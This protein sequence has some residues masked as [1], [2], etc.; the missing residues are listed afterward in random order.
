MS[1]SRF[2]WG[3]KVFAIGI[4]CSMLLGGC[5][6]KGDV[7]TGTDRI[8]KEGQVQDGDIFYTCKEI[9][10]PEP[11][12]AF[13]DVDENLI[14][15][16][17]G[18]V[19]DGNLYRDVTITDDVKQEFTYYRQ[20]LNLSEKEKADWELEELYSKKIDV[21]EEGA[22]VAPTSPTKNAGKNMVD[23]DENILKKVEGFSTVLLTGARTEQGKLYIANNQGIYEVVEDTPKLIFP[24]SPDY[25][26]DVI[27]G[28]EAKENGDI[29]LVCE[30]DYHVTLL[31]LRK[32]EEPV[33]RDREEI[34]L[35]L[36]TESQALNKSIARFNRQSEKYHIT[37]IFAAPNEDVRS[38]REKIIR[39]MTNGGGPDILN[40]D[41]FYEVDVAD[42]AENGYL[43][44]LDDLRPDSED[45]F[46]AAFDSLLINGK[47]YSIPFDFTIR[48][49]AY[50]PEVFTDNLETFSLQDMMEKVKTGNTEIL[51]YDRFGQGTSPYW[52]VM[53]YGLYDESNKAFIDW[54][55][56]LSHL[57]E[58]PFL[59]F[60][61]FAK[62]YGR[63]EKVSS[64]PTKRL[65]DGTVFSETITVDDLETWCELYYNFGGNPVLLGYPREDGNG[66]YLYGRE[67]Y[68][69]AN[70][71]CK[72]GA[73]EFLRFL[74]SREEQMRY[75][76]Y[77]TYEEMEYLGEGMSLYGYRADFPVYKDAMEVVFQRR[78]RQD[79][80]NYLVYLDGPVS[81]KMDER[82]EA[83]FYNIV[84]NAKPGRFR[85][86]DIADVV[87]EELQ[88][89]FEG[90][91]SAK[92]AA[93][94]LHERV[95][96]YL[97][98]QK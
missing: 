2:K 36:G 85:A 15:R 20:T 33:N 18:F 72:E 97:N 21:L 52:I 90:S 48:L 38:F 47:M 14:V 50:S 63:Q 37:T 80:K 86:D 30:M 57:N 44:C 3:R 43:E 4:V 62:E 98:E 92:E 95:Q 67:L 42:L 12:D 11:D 77:D 56:K 87:Y 23:V 51:S 76:R 10:F 60:L 58:E 9:A 46:Q 74:I 83:D 81:L 8:E 69:N 65:K 53:N 54:E 59:E 19:Y 16:K 17:G 75:V 78:R 70:S 82:M 29:D 28:M 45:Y 91:V 34:I 25:K 7:I 79:K 24:L 5:G 84:N 32:K 39:E 27:Y 40:W 6:N 13:S 49:A 66:C 1:D 89:Y 41:L 96:L 35:A 55:Q 61:E 64:F 22:G 94:K 31:E 73:K 93:G 71:K 68:V 88:P 26:L